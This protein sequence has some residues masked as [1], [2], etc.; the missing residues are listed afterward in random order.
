VPPSLP[1]ALVIAPCR[2]ADLP[3]VEEIERL[4]FPTPWD[5]RSFEEELERPFARLEVLREKAPGPVLAFCDY[6]LVADEV[7]I[8]N[9]AVHPSSRRQG[10]AGRLLTHI[11][12]QARLASFRWLSLEV[13]RSNLPAQALYRKFGFR[14]VGLR[15]RYYADNQED[16]VLMDLVLRE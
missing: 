16:A 13:R 11:V 5:R 12:E 6:W 1:H 10:C 3:A 8:L 4:S 9:I 14:D 15:P 7:Q 2:P